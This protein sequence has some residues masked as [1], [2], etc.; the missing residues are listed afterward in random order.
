M[1]YQPSQGDIV[2]INFDPQRGREIKKR[3]PALILSRDAYNQDTGF[4]IVSP[5]TSTIRNNKHGY[6]QLGGYQTKGQV[7]VRQVHSFDITEHSG[8]NVEFIEH[9]DDADFFQIS[10]LF[11]YNFNF[12]LAN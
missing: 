5:I 3:R 4:I 8:R 2:W 12:P 6:Y 9:I 11:L 1:M 10:Q 7:V